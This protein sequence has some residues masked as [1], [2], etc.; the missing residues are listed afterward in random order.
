MLHL[1]NTHNDINQGKTGGAKKGDTKGKKAGT[2]AGGKKKKKDPTAD[3]SM[4]SLY[5]ELVSNG[6]LVRTPSSHV[7]DFLGSS[8]YMGSTLDKAGIIPDP[9]M[10]QVGG[11]YIFC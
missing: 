10:A 5:A 9:S 7:Q 8:G 4:E 3:R 1:T 2:K 6:V 11:Y